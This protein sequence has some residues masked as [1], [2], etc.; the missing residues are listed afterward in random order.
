MKG[1]AVQV[2]EE[3]NHEVGND[4]RRASECLKC[5]RTLPAAMIRDPERELAVLK[6]HTEHKGL[7]QY[8]LSQV[9]ARAGVDRPWQGLAHRDFGR[10][11]FEEVIDLCAY[12]LGRAQQ[13]DLQGHE[14]ELSVSESMVLFHALEALKALLAADDD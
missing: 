3:C 11:A 1:D 4:P 12:M 9:Q 13:R 8:A 7:A 14:T 10:E 2:V 5:G 6:R